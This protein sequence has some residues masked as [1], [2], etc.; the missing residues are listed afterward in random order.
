MRYNVGGAQ[1]DFGAL[2]FVILHG[3]HGYI[4]HVGKAEREAI[5]K[6][7]QAMPAKLCKLKQAWC[8]L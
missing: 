3:P 4:Q 8:L 7:Y 2:H 6:E 1:P 5:T